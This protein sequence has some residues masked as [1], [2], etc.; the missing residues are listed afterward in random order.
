MGLTTKG[1][2]VLDALDEH[3][4]TT[5]RQLSKKAGISLGHV[6]YV[7]KAFLKKGLVKIDNFYQSPNKKGYA[8]LL[9]P[10]GIEEKSK[11]AVKFVLLKISICWASPSARRVS[12]KTSGSALADTIMT[13][14]PAVRSCSATR[15][16]TGPFPKTHVFSVNRYSLRK[17]S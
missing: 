11:L 17:Y 3:E 4:I 12:E 14:S 10:E 9:T 16:A 13:C 8:Y 1:F 5:Q 7:L 15:W 6:N 2:F